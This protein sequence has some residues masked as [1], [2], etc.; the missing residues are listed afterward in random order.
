MVT[1]DS[2]DGIVMRS[3]YGWAFM[4]PIRKVYYNLTITVISVLVAFVIGGIEMVQVLGSELGY[5]TG[6]WAALNALDFG[7][8]GYVVIA[9]FL[10]SWVVAMLYYRHKGY[11][12]KGI[13][14]E[15]PLLGGMPTSGSSP[16]IEATET[17]EGLPQNAGKLSKTDE[18]LSI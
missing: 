4:K 11:E 17:T 6:F 8:I 10:T 14:G 15:P 12:K 16:V 9:T 5:T 13:T 3:A 1:V 2:T 7:Q 18:H